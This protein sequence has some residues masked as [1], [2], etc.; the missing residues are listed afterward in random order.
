VKNVNTRF[1]SALVLIGLTLQPALAAE[2]TKAPGKYGFRSSIIIKG[3][4]R[5][6]DEKKFVKIAL[7]TDDAVVILNSNGG[8]IDPAIVIG[9]AV[10]V[11]NFGTA[12]LDT[13]CSS[14]CALIWLAGAPKLY[15]SN[16]FI[17]FHAASITDKAG[18]VEVSSEGNALIGA[19]LNALG[20]SDEVVR[21]ATDAKPSHIKIS[22][23][24]I[25]RDLGIPVTMIGHVVTD[26]NQHNQA[27]QYLF[28]P[29]KNPQKAVQLYRSAA[30]NGFAG[31]QN[32]LGDLY[33]KG[34]LV[35]K[36]DKFATYWYARAAERGEPTAYLSL[37]T[38]LSEGTKDKAVLV[39]AYKYAILASKYL[40]KGKNKARAEAK[41][42]ELWKI[43]SEK[44][45]RS[46]YA[47]LTG[48]AP[49]HQETAL[50][51]DI[52]K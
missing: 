3:S 18:K 30:S 5:E 46:A 44:E 49:L 4:I 43:L 14:S 2:I 13:S 33:E 20:L 10:R 7:E 8:L 42:E 21:Y 48:W 32:N 38:L 1:L 27:I 11:K 12:I 50:M 36:N 41:R 22:D 9:K 45:I 26:R 40:P 15:S 39:E 37:A 17:G 25:F 34:V 51:A 47:S 16:S 6:G 28:G 31:S 52:G 24:S 23:A 29:K 19:Y 35:P